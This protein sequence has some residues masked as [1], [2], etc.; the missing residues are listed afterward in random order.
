YDLPSQV[1]KT[2]AVNSNLNTV[3]APTAMI[4]ATSILNL[5]STA[6]G[7]ICTLFYEVNN[8]YGGA[9]GS[10]ATHYISKRTI[11]QLGV[12]GTASVVVRSVGLAS[13]AF[14][15]D[16]VSYMLT[17]FSTPLQPTNFLI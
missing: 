17:S 2:L 12:A 6:T 3:L 10:V 1:G 14:L 9:I 8:N 7:G 16:G 11:T 13:K 15:I 5:A 4:A